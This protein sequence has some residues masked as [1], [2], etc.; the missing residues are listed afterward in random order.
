MVSKTR[1]APDMSIPMWNGRAFNAQNP[2]AQ[3][4]DSLSI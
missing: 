4:V 2:V 3:G 1:P